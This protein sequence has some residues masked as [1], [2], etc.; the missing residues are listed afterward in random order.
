MWVAG[1]FLMAMAGLWQVMAALIAEERRMQIR[2][3]TA[4]VAGG[5]EQVT[6]R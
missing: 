4:A 5:S 2:E 3:R 6:G 1:T